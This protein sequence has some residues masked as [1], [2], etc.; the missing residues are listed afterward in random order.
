MI[1]SD[2]KIE[3]FLPVTC[4][5]SVRC[6]FSAAFFFFYQKLRPAPGVMNEKKDNLEGVSELHCDNKRLHSPNSFQFSVLKVSEPVG[7]R[8]QCSDITVAGEN[9]PCPKLLTGNLKLCKFRNADL[10]SCVYTKENVP[11]MGC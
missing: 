9:A 7:D 2:C 5:G 11:W 4:C 6:H 1:E 10:D 3:V 8:M